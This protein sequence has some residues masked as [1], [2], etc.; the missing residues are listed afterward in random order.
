M[1]T[2]PRALETAD[3][4]Q[5]VTS[6]FELVAQSGSLSERFRRRYAIVLAQLESRAAADDVLAARAVAERNPH[7]AAVILVHGLQPQLQP[8]ASSDKP[9]VEGIG[10]AARTVR[11][12]LA[13]VSDFGSFMASQPPLAQ[14]A[15][16]I[17]PSRRARLVQSADRSSGGLVALVWSA[18]SV[19]ARLRNEERIGELLRQFTS[20][21]GLR[22]EV[23]GDYA[24]V[25]VDPSS[26]PWA[27]TP[28]L[29][30]TLEDLLR[31]DALGSAVRGRVV[32]SLRAMRKAMLTAGVIWQG[33]APR[34]MFL[35]G[36]V[37][38]L[39]DFEEVVDAAVDPVRA[40]E[41]LLWHRI[42]F[43]D[44]LDPV[45]A[46]E[47][48]A[49]DEG[50]APLIEDG[51]PLAADSF[52]RALLNVQTISWQQRRDLL[53][54]SLRLEGRHAR[55]E[56]VRDRGLLHGHELGHFWGDFLPAAQEARLFS[57]LAS[58]SDPAMLVACLEV[59]EAAM[60]ADICRAITVNCRGEADGAPLRTEA[61]IDALD[62]VEV[63]DL[64]AERSRIVHWYDRLVTD[65]A[66]LVDEL[67][68]AVGTAV[69]GV[70]RSV[71]DMYLVGGSASRASH[72]ADL[73]SAVRVGLDFLH[74]SGSETPFLRHADPT[75]L[76]KT[77]AG[78]LPEAG[79]C[80]DHVLAEI[81][82]VIARHSIR[83]GHPR[84]LAFPDSGNALA[85]LAGSILSPLLNQNL[86]AVDRSAPSATFVEVQVIEW[87][88]AL[89]GYE[90]SPLTEL[91]GVKDVGG[92]WTTGGHL[93][94]H[95]AMLAALGRAYPQVRKLGLRALDTQPSVV[96]AGPIAHYSHSDAAFH[97][98]L[99][100]DS[101]LSVG[102][103]RGFTT[104]PAAVDRLLADPPAG[105]TPFMVVGVAG[106]C[107]TTG[108]DDLEALG[109]VCRRHGVWFHVDA[110]HGG[111]LIF[112]ERLRS[113]HLAGIELADS[114]SL[115]PHKGLF[116]PYPS[117]YV[118]FRDRAVLTQFSRHE[119]AVMADD[120]WDL[121]LITPFLGSRGFQS[122][123]TWM[124]LRHVGTRTLG[125]MVE[126]RQ[127]IVRYLERRVDDSGL[128]VRLNDVDFYRLAFVFCPPAFRRA[129]A[130]LD[131][132]GRLRAAKVISSYTSRL[133]TALYQSGEVCF[134]E[135]TL[136]DLDDRIGAGAGTS[137]TIMAACPGNPLVTREDLD[138]AMKKLVSE[139]LA[140]VEPMLAEL[141]GNLPQQT[142]RRA[143]GPAGWSDVE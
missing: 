23:Q 35:R 26:D 118:L 136:G 85:A 70:D 60:E 11:D 119:A 14:T 87:L 4:E 62:A 122:L 113:Q 99:G 96:M 24:L 137:Y 12:L 71:L 84:Y 74:G 101:V 13:T 45:E 123:A 73:T 21:S 90:D 79:S 116:T 61:V 102:T 19:E 109:E 51:H 16:P 67:L 126:S 17:H 15:V 110:C 127:A 63:G 58:V 100:W 2:T 111:S 103:E 39:I 6:W 92:L 72:E 42:F 117:S 89:V 66:Q 77:I 37:I 115:D 32:V 47:L 114:V 31:S 64:A 5:R 106:N 97:L 93:S 53:W 56:K 27:F 130:E 1:P 52:E 55:P 34:N 95:V 98:G 138:A 30:Q 46:E 128:F 104:D 80:F 107:R 25:R 43:A 86:I 78:P 76:Q 81:E 132:A 134:D 140:L 54:Q 124:L 65:P 41:C 141:R 75:A 125:A 105:R 82:E 129:M 28:N 38:V 121:G 83:Q 139:A 20:P 40:A 143:G 9:T 88:R 18:E 57:H 22:F 50:G 29:G 94:N 112:S 8:S 135:H 108:L 133:N 49:G 68:L 59:F 120:C 91:R 142:R 131:P 7:G 10:P 33:F 44:C 48:F 3:H 69:G 36:E